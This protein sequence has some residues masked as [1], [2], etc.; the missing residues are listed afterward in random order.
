[1]LKVVP[2]LIFVLFIFIIFSPGKNFALNQSDTTKVNALID[3]SLQ[4]DKS[5][6][7]TVKLLDEALTISDKTGYLLM[8][9]KVLHNLGIT[10]C[11][12]GEYSK[13]LNYLFDELKL[14]ENNPKWD[15]LLLEK[16]YSVIGEA[17]RAIGTYDLALENLNKALK[18][19]IDNGDEKGQANIYN[20]LAA[21]YHEISFK[22]F[23]TAASFKADELANKSINLTDNSKDKELYI[24]NLNIIG[25]A[26]TFRNDVKNALKYFLLALDEADKLDNYADKPNIMNN[27]A[28]LYNQIGDY[29]TAIEYALKSHIISDKSGIKVYRLESARDLIRSYIKLGEYKKACDYYEEA[30]DLVMDMYSVKKAAEISGLN[31][32][33]EDELKAQEEN[34]NSSKKI[35]FGSVF[36]LVILSVGA[37]LFLKH[38]NQV[39]LN[40]ELSAKN[41]L[42]SRQKEQLTQSNAAKDKFFS[43]LSHD[44][45]NPLNGLLGFSKILEMEFDNIKDDE[46]KEYIGYI[47]SSS[48][49]LNKLIDKTLMWSRLQTGKIKVQKEKINLNEIATTVVELQ[50]VNAIRKGIILENKISDYIF[51]YAD[52]NIVDTVIRN[53]T[54]NAIKFTE[55]G[56]KVFVNANIINDNVELSITDTGVGMS[57]THLQKLFKIDEKISSA[58][59]HNEEGTGLGLILCKEM[60]VLMNSD[61]KVE[62]TISEGSKFYFILPLMN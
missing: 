38:R 1:M 48:D 35:M 19:S 10:Y 18:I 30:S 40:Q 32:K 7:E 58:G 21:V 57:E 3:S 6:D 31:K 36:I 34:K 33:F 62:S 56:G 13:S 53:L 37:G 14:R 22:E 25:A 50:K 16:N 61:L 59:T 17:F 2:R 42:I 26:Y 20:R 12:M 47:K 5:L 39:K 55:A 15:I 52:K 44:L 46:K 29:K 45:R 8:K 51:V 4:K 41:E 43:I 11:K 54:D 9:A 49:S 28:T 27:I 24:S 60:L 23:D